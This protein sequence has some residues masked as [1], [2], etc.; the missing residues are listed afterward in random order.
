MARMK[1]FLDDDGNIPKD[2]HSKVFPNSKPDDAEAIRQSHVDDDLDKLVDRTNITYSQ[3][4]NEIAG[5][6]VV[7]DVPYD[8]EALEPSVN[9]SIDGPSV[10]LGDRAI[11]LASAIH[12]GSKYNSAVAYE[13]VLRVREP[14]RDYEK[15]IDLTV[16]KEKIY[17]KQFNEAFNNAIG[18]RAI[19]AAGYDPDLAAS[20]ADTMRR[21]FKET[22]LG[23]ENK[24]SR[25]KFRKVLE[26]YQK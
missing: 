17:K 5:S 2:W 19:I 11:G 3:A 20:D 7:V 1:D 9:K 4:I 24:R 6:D 13:S 16:G 14:K 26:Y 23:P 8:T 22:Y 12:A 10:K 18:L 21:E 15:D 25:A